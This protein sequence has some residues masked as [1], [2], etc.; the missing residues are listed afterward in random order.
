MKSERFET[1]E[2]K[3]GIKIGPEGQEKE[4]G[5]LDIHV[6]IT[7]QEF[8]IEERYQTELY[9]PKGEIHPYVD[10]KG[11]A[12]KLEEIVF[13]IKGKQV[14]WIPTIEETVLARLESEKKK[15]KSNQTPN[16]S[17]SFTSQDAVIRI[18]HVL[19]HWDESLVVTDPST[20]TVEGSSTAVSTKPPAVSTSTSQSKPQTNVMPVSGDLQWDHPSLASDAKD[21]K[22]KESTGTVRFFR[23]G[24]LHREDGPAVVTDSWAS[25]YLFGKY[26]SKSDFDKAIKRIDV[27]RTGKMSPPSNGGWKTHT[28][29]NGI[30]EYKVSGK[31]HRENGPAYIDKHRN[32]EDYYLNGKKYDK[33][34][35]WKVIEAM[36]RRKAIARM[37][38]DI[39]SAG[40]ST[41]KST[42]KTTMTTSSSSGQ[43]NTSKGTTTS[44]STSSKGMSRHGKP[45]VWI[46][47]LAWQKMSYWAYLG[48]KQGQEITSFGRT[49]R[50]K[51]G[52]IRILDA[53]LIEQEG[54]AGSVDG[55]DSSI[56][57]LMVEM[58]KEHGID[59]AEALGTWMHSHPG[60]GNSATY[61]S[62]TDEENIERILGE[63]YLVSVVLDQVGESPYCRVDVKNPRLS[64]E[65][66][67]KVEVPGR[68]HRWSELSGDE[69]LDQL[70]D[71]SD[72]K[73]EF[74]EKVKSGYS[75]MMGYAGYSSYRSGGV[76]GGLRYDEA[77]YDMSSGRTW[78]SG[79]KG[80]YPDRGGWSGDDEEE[81]WN[82]YLDRMYDQDD[83]VPNAPVSGHRAKEWLD[84]LDPVQPFLI[85]GD[86]G[87]LDEE[88]GFTQGLLAMTSGSR[89]DFVEAMSMIDAAAVEEQVIEDTCDELVTGKMNEAE[90]VAFVSY[91]CSVSKDVGKKMIED[92]LMDNGYVDTTSFKEL[93]DAELLG[94]PKEISEREDR[95]DRVEVV[96]IEIES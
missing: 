45:V 67:L 23:A 35:Y 17:S 75:S 34:V 16:L 92:S 51:R 54:T 47:P 18:L 81:L 89:K 27:I 14:D 66:D 61:L 46:T 22:V 44:S 80:V 56:N 24:V 86:D 8:Y 91:V 15:K 63:E 73:A 37:I 69:A 26:F 41:G 38:N 12:P 72:L 5:P 93:T 62:S 85:A 58:F 76:Y 36:T 60:T 40:T 79:S 78:I 9:G 53:Y 48:G 87:W 3:H 94:V 25:H 65:C 31:L 77:E 21:T 13:E 39:R 59:P 83:D 68:T 84:A 88:I 1:W 2:Y 55:D 6:D 71:L 28:T 90:A 29:K 74:K 42:G 33:D 70:A 7:C 49:V 19:S 96:E 20:F 10:A 50:D 57:K 4:Y 30:D 43:S 52:R 64:F 82:R 32:I 11:L 95:T